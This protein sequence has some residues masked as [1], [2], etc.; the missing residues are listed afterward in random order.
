[1]VQKKDSI[2]TLFE[3]DIDGEFKTLFRLLLTIALLILFLCTYLFANPFIDSD[4]IMKNK[5][6]TAS[7]VCRIDSRLI[8]SNSTTS[9]LNNDL[10]LC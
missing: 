8:H 6:V 3:G 4:S 5:E 2:D 7:S 1:M 10:P 9:K